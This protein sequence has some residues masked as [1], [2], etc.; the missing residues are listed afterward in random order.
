M[1]DLVEFIRQRLDERAAQLAALLNSSAP[2]VMWQ[3]ENRDAGVFE[4]IGLEVNG[5]K[6]YHRWW[7]GATTAEDVTDWGWH[8]HES[9]VQLYSHAETERALR[10]VEAK[11]RLLDE[12]IEVMEGDYAP[13]NA[14]FVRLLAAPYADHPAYEEGWRP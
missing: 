14:G 12:L 4:C 6:T 2:N 8:L 3:P 9:A 7:V 1:T 5:A 13:W 11:R 10:D